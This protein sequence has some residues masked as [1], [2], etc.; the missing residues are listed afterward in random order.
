MN[1]VLK[2]VFYIVFFFISTSFI[3]FILDGIVNLFTISSKS[4]IYKIF[5]NAPILIGFGVTK[6]FAPDLYR[7]L[8]KQ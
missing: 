1:K 4:I 6:L 8:T 7:N 2:W 5:V 3:V